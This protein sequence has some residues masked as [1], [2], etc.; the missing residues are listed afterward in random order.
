[1]R[2]V[3]PRLEAELATARGGVPFTLQ[4]PV[5]VFASADDAMQLGLFSVLV[6]RVSP[7]G[8]A[9]FW[10]DCAAGSLCDAAG[11]AVFGLGV[12]GPIIELTRPPLLQWVRIGG[13]A[14]SRRII[15]KQI[16]ATP[17]R[18][19]APVDVLEITAAGAT[20]VRRDPASLCQR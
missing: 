4:Q 16:A 17:G 5:Q 7:L 3:L 2:E 15:E 10:N 19:G 6:A 12:D 9:A 11:R 18:V 13:A 14:A 20:W 8:L 1:L